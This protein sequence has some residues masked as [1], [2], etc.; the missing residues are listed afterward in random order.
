MT[1]RKDKKKSNGRDYYPTSMELPKLPSVDSMNNSFAMIPMGY[2]MMAANPIMNNNNGYPMMAATPIMNNNGYPMMT[3]NTLSYQTLPMMTPMERGQQMVSANQGKLEKQRVEVDNIKENGEIVKI[4]DG[5]D[6][7]KNWF[8]DLSIV[9]YIMLGIQLGHFFDYKTIMCM[10]LFWLIW[11]N[12][13]VPV[14]GIKPQEL[15]RSLIGAIFQTMM[16]F[17]L[18]AQSKK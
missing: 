16:N 12:N 5:T 11:Q 17:V 13:P 4:I 3:S 1:D 6:N 7:E 9:A 14:A 8:R 10:L 15:I 18:R 2:S